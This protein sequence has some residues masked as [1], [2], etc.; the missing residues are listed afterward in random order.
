MAKIAFLATVESESCENLLRVSKM[1]ISGFE[2]DISANAR[3]TARR[4][5]GSPYRNYKLIKKTTG[6]QLIM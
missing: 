6:A 1:E 4:M 2:V 3:G 5:T